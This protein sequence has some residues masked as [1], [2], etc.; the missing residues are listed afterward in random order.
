MNQDTCSLCLGGS[1]DIP[2]FGT[3]NDAKDL[4]H[5]CG[6][7]S[8]VTHRKCLLD[9][10]TSLPPSKFVVYDPQTL[11]R[12]IQNSSTFNHLEI[13]S[14]DD[15]VN[16]FHINLSPTSITNWVSELSNQSSPV[17]VKSNVY[18][19]SP[20]PQC[21]QDIMFIMK[22][23]PLLGFNSSIR[24]MLSRG[25][26][27]SGLF[28]GLTSAVT[29]VVSMGYIGLTSCGLRMMNSIIPESLLL[30][31]LTKSSTSSNS[32]SLLASLLSPS[33]ASINSTVDNLEVALS[34]GLIDP[35]KFSR[36]PALPIL[37]YR[38]RQLS[39]LQLFIGDRKGDIMTNWAT[40]I[41]IN[42]YISS[43]GDHK[44]AKLLCQNLSEVIT[45]FVKN[46]LSINNLNLFKGIDFW[47]VKNMISMLIPVRILY[48][49]LFR[50]TF[51]RL[52]FD[53]TMKYK[54]RLI[55]NDLPESEFDRFETL[56][57][58]VSEISKI[59]HLYE[60]LECQT[61][62]QWCQ[63]KVNLVKKLS[64]DKLI[65]KYVKLKIVLSVLKLKACFKKDYSETINQTSFAL[66]CL[67]TVIWPFLSSKLGA[68]LFPVLS[69]HISGSVPPE[70]IAFLGNL[71][72]MGLVVVAKDLVNVSL[73]YKK[74]NQL[75][76]IE[77]FNLDGVTSELAKNF[78]ESEI[79]ERTLESDAF[80]GET[81]N[82]ADLEV[83]RLD[84]PDFMSGSTSFPGGFDF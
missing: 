15:T 82:N 75:T 71:I 37:L 58:Q 49:T 81:F 69:K 70:N 8:I 62:T 53:I 35:F 66:K 60:N 45:R 72:A 61:F 79:S 1:T 25:L 83:P 20:C 38:M 32:L 23:S 36:V 12:E 80:G 11:S 43:L 51:N 48:E 77:I 41:M 9:W 55:A 78:R 7:C 24:T 10:F 76:T 47:N 57:G 68:V 39:F 3:I 31:L 44:L 17:K 42:G 52:H 28:L 14:G 64:K 34:R 46:P 50:L 6:T 74:L 30:K 73:G 5:P 4:I 16:E 56:T 21:K 63:S 2:P 40:E 65:F 84:G 33:A 54:P 27:Y 18:I 59:L 67:T 22:I 26:K 13:G 19:L 29:G